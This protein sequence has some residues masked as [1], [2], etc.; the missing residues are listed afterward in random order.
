MFK[1]LQGVESTS[2]ALAAQRVQMEIVS[3]NIANTNTTRGPD[4]LPYQRQH[5]SFESVLDQS[6]GASGTGAPS[7][8][9]SAIQKDNTP[10]RMVYNPGHPDAGAD[11]MV[12]YPAINIHEEMVD[13]LAASRAYEANLSVMRNARDMATQTLSVLRS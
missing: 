11:G 9:I 12:A 4:G 10:P 1:L 3:Q 8:R 7:V 6:T 5:V 2:S 13:L